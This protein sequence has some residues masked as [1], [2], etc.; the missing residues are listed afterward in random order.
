MVRALLAA[1]RCEASGEAGFSD[2]FCTR[3]PEARYQVVFYKDSVEVFR[4]GDPDN[5]PRSFRWEP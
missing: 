2:L 4:V 3:S 1:T 5:A